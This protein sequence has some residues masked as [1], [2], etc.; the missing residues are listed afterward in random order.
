M[1]AAT[2]ARTWRQKAFVRGARRQAA[3]IEL[4]DGQLNLARQALCLQAGETLGGVDDDIHFGCAES[5]SAKQ[6]QGE[7]EVT[8][9]HAAILPESPLA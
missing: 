7:A 1:G 9:Q 3:D 6:D 5:A 8:K 2:Q 4:A